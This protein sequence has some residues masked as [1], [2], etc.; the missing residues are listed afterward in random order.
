[1]ELPLN[2]TARPAAPPLGLPLAFDSVAVDALA[3]DRQAIAE[4][5]ALL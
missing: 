4:L 1:M 2:G 5:D 3:G